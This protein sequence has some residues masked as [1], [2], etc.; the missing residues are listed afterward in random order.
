MSFICDFCS[1]PSGLG[2]KPI[3]VTLPSDVR[4]VKYSNM[5]PQVKDDADDDRPVRKVV[6]VKLVHKESYGSEFTRELSQCPSC[7]GLPVKAAPAVVNVY[8][9][10]KGK[11]FDSI[12][13]SNLSLLLQEPLAKPYKQS[14]PRMAG[15]KAL[16]RAHDRSKRGKRE[17][18]AFLSMLNNYQ[19]RGGRV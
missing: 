13:L 15:E 12:P 6:K 9:G 16:V 19:S 8:A 3:M 11:N 7:A 14:L 1:K 4:A 10:F 18:G 17:A 5:V 2:V